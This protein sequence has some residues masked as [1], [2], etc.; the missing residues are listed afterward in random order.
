MTHVFDNTNGASLEDCHT[1]F[2]ALA[3]LNGIKWSVSPGL[4]WRRV[5]VQRA[6]I[7]QTHQESNSLSCSKELWI[8]WYGEGPDFS[9]LVESSLIEAEQGSLES[10]LSY[11]CR[12]LLFKALHNLI[13]RCLLSRGYTRIGRYF[14]EPLVLPITKRTVI[15]SPYG[16][17]GKL[18]GVGYKY[19][20]PHMAR[21]LNNWH[22]FYLHPHGRANWKITVKCPVW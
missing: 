22:M 12:T 19:N 20:D 4:V 11:E 14:V 5:L 8:F 21:F 15:L 18:T 13:E 2:F 1:N 16:M 10:G 9:G 6:E 7:H 3:D 17:E